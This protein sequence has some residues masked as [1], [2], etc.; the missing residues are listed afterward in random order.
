LGY[1]NHN[2]K[3]KNLWHLIGNFFIGI[4]PIV[5]GSLVLFLLIKYLVPD[6]QQL[7]NLIASQK[8]DFSS[9]QGLLKQFS[10]LYYSGKIAFFSL[11]TYNNIHSWQFWIFLYLAL[12]ISSHMELSPSDLK[13]VWSGFLAI[14]IFLFNFNG[15]SIYF[16]MEHKYLY[17]LHWKL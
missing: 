8:V 13:G 16:S 7:L 11:F 4:G 3:P 6:N 9:W 1:V 12:S 17:I 10:V 14:F 2:Y 15:L 5:F